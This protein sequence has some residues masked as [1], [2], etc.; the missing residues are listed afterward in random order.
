MFGSIRDPYAQGVSHSISHPGTLIQLNYPATTG[1]GLVTRSDLA[2]AWCRVNWIGVVEQR[3][4]LLHEDAVVDTLRL[5]TDADAQC[6]RLL[7]TR[8]GALVHAQGT[9]AATE[10]VALNAGAGI[11]R[12]VAT[13]T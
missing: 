10:G 8:A 5:V 7:V 9:V 3:H 6:I 13:V 2:I 12:R 4:V 11:H 1:E